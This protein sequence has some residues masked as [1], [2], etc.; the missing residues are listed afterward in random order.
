MSLL[1]RAAEAEV[2]VA[3]PAVDSAADDLGWLGQ[4]TGAPELP[5][6]PDTDAE[7]PEPGASWVPPRRPAP[8][9]APPRRRQFLVTGTTAVARAGPRPLGGRGPAPRPSASHAPATLR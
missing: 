1:V 3:R 4:G 2:A 6:R 7:P 5:T 8:A 9:A